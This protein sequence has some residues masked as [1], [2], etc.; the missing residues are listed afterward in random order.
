M[1]DP[2]SSP[3]RALIS[4]PRHVVR[5]G[6]PEPSDHLLQRRII[7][8]TADCICYGWRKKFQRWSLWHGN[9]L[10]TYRAV[11]FSETGHVVLEKATRQLLLSSESPSWKATKAFKINQ[12]TI[13]QQSFGKW[14]LPEFELTFLVA[15]KSVKALFES[16]FPIWLPEESIKTIN[17]N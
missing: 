3:G 16:R 12:L 17:N 4:L 2:G 9:I 6:H 5:K 1:P 15:E 8:G 14:I 13:G 11:D 7:Y 10:Q